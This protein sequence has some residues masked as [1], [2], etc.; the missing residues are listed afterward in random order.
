M[1]QSEK[2]E[3]VHTHTVWLMKVNGSRDIGNTK[4]CTILQ[5]DAE[6]ARGSNA[7]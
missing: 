4:K 7:K 6:L 5:K 1:R 3:H 2:K